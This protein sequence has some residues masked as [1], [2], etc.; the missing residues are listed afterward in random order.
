MEA[1]HR[2]NE[3]SL[4]KG[5]PI[6][7]EKEV[8]SLEKRRLGRRSYESYCSVEGKALGWKSMNKS[9]EGRFSSVMRKDSRIVQAHTSP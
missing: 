3:V 6:I 2:P 1:T 4:G 7:E 9:Q 5:I 8:F